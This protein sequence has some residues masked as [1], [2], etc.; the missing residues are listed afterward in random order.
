[1]T[2][3]EILMDA[4]KAIDQEVNVASLPQGS[5]ALSC[6]SLCLSVLSAVIVCLFGWGRSA[7]GAF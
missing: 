5:L 2:S 4:W 1:M 3:G 7:A 6:L